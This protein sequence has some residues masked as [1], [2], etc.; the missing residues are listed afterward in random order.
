VRDTFYIGYEQQGEV[1]VV[2][3]FDKNTDTSEEIFFNVNGS[4]EQDEELSGSMM[5]RPG[6]SRNR[7]ITSTLPEVKE[8]KEEIRIY[9]N[10]GNGRF[11]IKGSYQQLLIYDLQ[12]RLLRTYEASHSSEQA[13]STQLSTGMY[14]L[15]IL[16]ENGQ[17]SRKLIIR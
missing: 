13:I 17:E 2:V 5:M 3:G 4:W 7:V 9:P 6:F 15:K 10:P 14:L 1:F 16:K 12:G 11:F 8:R